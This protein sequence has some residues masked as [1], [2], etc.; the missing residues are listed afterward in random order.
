[1]SD[2]IYRQDA[3]DAIRNADFHFTIKSDINFADY[4]ETVQEIFNN[5]LDAQQQALEQ[6]PSAQLRKIG[7]WV[8][9]KCNQ[10]GQVDM[11]KPNF[12]P[13]C[14]ARMDGESDETD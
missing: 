12:C 1:M 7:K 5:V 8:D 14:G 3:I 2:M 10:C 4:R 9:L 11:S 6:L 13:N